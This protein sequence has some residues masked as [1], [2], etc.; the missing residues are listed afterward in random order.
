M[1]HFRRIFRRTLP[2]V[3]AAG[4]T[5]GLTACSSSDP[6]V[7]TL[8]A[9]PGSA[10]AGGPATVEV[11]TPAVP[12]GLDRD[13]IVLADTGS[14]LK[15]SSSDAWSEALGMEIGHALTSDLTGR[16]PG[17]TVFSQAD[18]MGGT[19]ALVV[20]SVIRRF[21]RDGSGTAILEMQYTIKRASDKAP[22]PG[23]LVR[24]TAPAGG[25]TQAF[26]TAFSRLLG[27]AADRIAEDIRA[28]QPARYP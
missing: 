19:A 25:S 27:E 11:L 13:R 14:R 16:L 23:R 4:L 21:T 3:L 26:V 10:I 9:V 20:E 8:S 15:I 2:A 18:G 17:S 28:V 1:T 22:S 6:S 24:L 12:Q 5:A 7:W